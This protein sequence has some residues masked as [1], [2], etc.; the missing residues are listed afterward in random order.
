VPGGNQVRHKLNRR[1]KMK[2]ITLILTILIV[3]WSI[4]TSRAQTEFYD[5]LTIEKAITLTLTNN[6]AVRQAECGMTASDA[7]VEINRSSRYPDIAFDGTYTRIGPVPS[8]EL[9]GQGTLNF[10]PFNNY[11]LHIGFRQ[12]LYDFGRINETINIAE[13]S[14]QSAADNIEMVKS[15]LA[16]QTLALFNGILILQ[17]RIVVLDEQLQTLQQHLDVSVKKMQAGTATDFDTLTIQVKIAIVKNDRIDADHALETQ[18][19][20]LRQLTGLPNSTPINLSGNFDTASV[21]IHPDSLINVAD[22]QRPELILARDNEARSMS[23]S[24]LASLGDRPRLYFNAMTGFKNGYEPNLNTWRG[25]FAAGLNLNIPLFNGHRTKHQVARAQA[26]LLGARARTADLERQ[27]SA[28]VMKAA[29]GVNSSL[30]KFASTETQVHQAEQAV[31]MA[32]VR[33][34]SGVNTNLDLLDAEM[35]LSQTKL[36]R[37]RAFYDYTVSLN[38]LDRATGKKIW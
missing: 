38:E 20:M 24:Q 5:S 19:I 30:E 31:S 16:Y 32:R 21:T 23:Q 3:A 37:L 12:L 33:Y 27:I 1:L 14:K 11:D 8:F 34:S 36:I 13:K 2:K 6:P 15:R 7:Q 9:P 4:E 22:K 35:T 18:K 28:E 25:N 26:N 29:A 10:A 17:Q